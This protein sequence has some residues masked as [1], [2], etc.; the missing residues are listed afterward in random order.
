ME[1]HFNGASIQEKG[2]KLV[3]GSQIMKLLNKG[4]GH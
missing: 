3:H 2:R 1:A 4:R